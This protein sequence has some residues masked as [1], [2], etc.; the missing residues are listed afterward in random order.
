M[1]LALVGED[2]FDRRLDDGVWSGYPEKLS[3]T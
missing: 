2:R 1:T 3:E